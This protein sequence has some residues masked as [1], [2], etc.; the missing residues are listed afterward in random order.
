[1]LP[2]PTPLRSQ[3]NEPGDVHTSP[4]RPSNPLRSIEPE[5]RAHQPSPI[6]EPADDLTAWFLSAKRSLSS[7]TLCSRAHD[8][9]DA[10]RSA[11]QE[12]SVV[13]SRCVFLRASLQ[14]QL[15]IASQ[16]NR[17][18][19]TTQ[20]VARVEFEVC[21]RIYTPFETSLP[22]PYFEPEKKKRPRA[23]QIHPDSY[24]AC[25]CNI[26]VSGRGRS[27]AVGRMVQREVD[28]GMR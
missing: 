11:L 13:S 20:D 6:Q 3:P 26:S 4:A 18:M 19:H 10:A 7:I 8:L 5:S 28:I 14:D 2:P 25:R 1:M 17:M 16:V 15:N 23:V 24:G 22:C 21:L 9:V 27:K 12:A